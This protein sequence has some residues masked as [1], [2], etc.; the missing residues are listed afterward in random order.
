MGYKCA[1]LGFAEQHVGIHQD[2]P[3]RAIVVTCVI[4]FDL[5]GTGAVDVAIVAGADRAEPVDQ[6]IRR[7]QVVLQL[8]A[9]LALG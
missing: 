7:R 3:G 1:L 5:I 6:L 9:Q 8:V 4:P 2:L